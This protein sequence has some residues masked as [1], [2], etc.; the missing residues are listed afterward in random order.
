MPGTAPIQRLPVG[1]QH[2]LDP[3]P[4]P[5]L[6]HMPATADRESGAPVGPEAS[7]GDDSA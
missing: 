4:G 6:P 1:H 5:G 3:F 2:S 7:D